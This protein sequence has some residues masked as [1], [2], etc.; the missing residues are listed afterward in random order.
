M[1][2]V[3]RRPRPLGPRLIAVALVMAA[4]G[5]ACSRSSFVYV[6][7]SD[8]R[9]FFKV[10]GNWHFYGKRDL[11]EA[12]GLSKSPE[13]AR[14][15][16][17]LVGFDSDPAPDAKHVVDGLS[18]YPSVLAQV[19]GLSSLD[20]DQVSLFGLRN[21][22]YELEKA[23]QANQAEII[24]YHD[25]SLPGGFH[26]NRIVFDLIL[27]PVSS[28]GSNFVLRVDQTELLDEGTQRLYQFLVRCESRCFAA[29]QDIIN[30]IVDSWTVKE[31]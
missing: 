25:L 28:I 12:M 21:R 26:G 9:A 4:V 5:S 1:D 8:H 16:Q 29:N 19:T 13:A 30:Q 24:S 27:R 6:A 3:K 20:R 22:N 23:L 15:N 2:A 11:L 31:R 18:A 10:P 17:F 14:Q 7:S